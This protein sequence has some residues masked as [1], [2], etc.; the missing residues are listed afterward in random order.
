MNVHHAVVLHAV[1][2]EAFSTLLQYETR[3]HHCHVTHSS[4]SIS[5]FVKNNMYAMQHQLPVMTLKTPSE[6]VRPVTHPM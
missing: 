6:H 1:A 3:H 2:W 4:L 5:K